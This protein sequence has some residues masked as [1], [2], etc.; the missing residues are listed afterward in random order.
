[1]LNTESTEPTLKM[2]IVEPML[3]IERTEPADTI[4]NAD[5]NA[6]MLAK[7]RTLS[8]LKTLSRLLQ[9]SLQTYLLDMTGAFIGAFDLCTT[10]LGCCFDFGFLRGFATSCRSRIL[11]RAFLNS[12]Q[13]KMLS[14]FLLVGPPHFLKHYPHM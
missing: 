4:L 10:T 13:K 11:R 8:V 7:L 3:S 6:P 9:F 12:Y 1:M 5:A 14:P 2:D